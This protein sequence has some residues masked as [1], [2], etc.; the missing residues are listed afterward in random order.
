[1][2]GGYELGCGFQTQGSSLAAISGGSGRWVAQLRWG[3][4]VQTGRRNPS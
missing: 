2:S 3:A 4:V 1:M